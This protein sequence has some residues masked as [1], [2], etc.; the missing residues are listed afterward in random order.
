MFAKGIENSYPTIKSG[1]VRVDEME[2]C[3]HYEHWRKDFDLL[4]ELGFRYLR[5][6]PPIHHVWLSPNRYDWS[7]PDETFGVLRALDVV[8]IADLYRTP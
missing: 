7:F 3:G 2:K 6:G 1:S 5:Y 4:Q 8:P